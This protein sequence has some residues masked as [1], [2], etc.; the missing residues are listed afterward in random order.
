[1]FVAL[2]YKNGITARE[3]EL[4]AKVNPAK[5]LDLD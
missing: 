2:M 5:L 3:I 4:M 1:M